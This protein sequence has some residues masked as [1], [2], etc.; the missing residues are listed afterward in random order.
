[1]TNDL[2]RRVGKHRDGNASK[3]TKRYDVTRLVWFEPCSNINDAI[4]RET[5][6]KRWPR[7]WKIDLIERDNPRWDDL[8]VRLTG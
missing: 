6:L 5:S 7:N 2:P 4:Q 1:V 3:F 8:G